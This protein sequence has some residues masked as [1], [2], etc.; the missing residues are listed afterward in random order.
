MAKRVRR[1]S[2]PAR[3]RTRDTDLRRKILARAI[4]DPEFRRRL[5]K[6][7]EAVFEGTFTKADAAALQRMKVTLPAL[8]DVVTSLAGEVLC[9]GGGGCGGL[10]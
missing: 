7:P 2:S 10:A 3:A 9:G 4:V 6:N 1:G 5:F 8:D